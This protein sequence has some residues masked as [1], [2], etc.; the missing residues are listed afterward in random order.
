[1]TALKLCTDLL[2]I[3][4]QLARLRRFAFKA[5]VMPSEHVEDLIFATRENE[6]AQRAAQMILAGQFCAANDEAAA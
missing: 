2:A 1:M 5:N 6:R 4:R 3:Q